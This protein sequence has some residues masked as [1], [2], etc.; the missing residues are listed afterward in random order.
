MATPRDALVGAV[1]DVGKTP[2]GKRELLGALSADTPDHEAVSAW[3][4]HATAN[5]TLQRTDVKRWTSELEDTLKALKQALDANV[6][7]AGP[8][9]APPPSSAHPATLAAAAV[10]SAL[11]ELKS[12]A[13]TTKMLSTMGR[14]T[15]NQ[16]AACL[17]GPL[18][19]TREAMVLANRAIPPATG[20]MTEHAKRNSALIVGGALAAGFAY[21]S[22]TDQA[23]A[24]LPDGPVHRL[25]YT[26]NGLLAD[27]LIALAGKSSVAEADFPDMGAW[28]AAAGDVGLRQGVRQ[29]APFAQ[30]G[31]LGSV[32][33]FVA[34]IL[35]PQRAPAATA[36]CEDYFKRTGQ[37]SKYENRVLVAVIAAFPSW[38]FVSKPLG[39]LAT[40]P[41]NSLT[42]PG[43]KSVLVENSVLKPR[44]YSPAFGGVE[45]TDVHLRRAL[46]CKTASMGIMDAG[47]QK[48]G[49]TGPSAP[50]GTDADQT[51]ALGGFTAT[52]KFTAA[53]ATCELG[54]T[55]GYG[56]LR[57]GGAASPPASVLGRMTPLSDPS[58]PIRY[59][60]V[61]RD[62]R[63]AGS[64]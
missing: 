55:V 57:A 13:S 64:T 31:S 62:P 11:D 26:F 29:A 18:V 32:S 63:E 36:A 17:T 45:P 27:R 51:A 50:T 48:C 46:A 5:K 3:R 14:L 33:K 53:K 37:W 39:P 59:R 30:G 4:A 19:R 24:P 49:Y 47:P 54:G 1:D 58:M 23:A 22:T 60:Q 43:A 15:A 56:G 44:L 9:P 21:I 34:H 12:A 16:A 40:M 28:K 52:V 6:P 7:P 61:H 8:G 38:F 10:T 41:L 2:L 35:G 20:T 25:V 42:P